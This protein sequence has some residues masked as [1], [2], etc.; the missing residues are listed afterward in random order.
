MTHGFAANVEDKQIVCGALATA[1]AVGG[2]V[3]SL[4][5]Q[6]KTGVRPQVIYVCGGAQLH[7]SIPT[8]PHGHN[9]LQHMKSWHTFRSRWTTPHSHAS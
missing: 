7:M 6:S 8:E 3:G 1:S 2:F 9:D 5:R 4:E